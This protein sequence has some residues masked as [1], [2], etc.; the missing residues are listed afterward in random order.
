MSL[1]SPKIRERDF[2]RFSSVSRFEELDGG[3]GDRLAEPCPLVVGNATSVHALPVL[4]D[5]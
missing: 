3:V 5:P 2:C 4:L 1:G